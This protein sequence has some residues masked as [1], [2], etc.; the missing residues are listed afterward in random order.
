MVNKHFHI[1]AKSAYFIK[2]EK[3]EDT[4]TECNQLIYFIITKK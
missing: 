2:S 1:G 3:F 4:K